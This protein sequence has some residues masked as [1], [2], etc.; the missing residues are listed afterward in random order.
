MSTRP[1]SSDRP[2]GSTAGAPSSLA[3]SEAS[4]LAQRYGTT[5]GA[6]WKRWTLRGLV[7]VVVALSATWVLWAMNG[8]ARP[9]S[10]PS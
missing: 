4:D 6:P 8:H 10:T 1:A 7:A 5:G 2:S 9:P 3:E